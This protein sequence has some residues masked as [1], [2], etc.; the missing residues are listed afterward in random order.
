[1]EVFSKYGQLKLNNPDLSHQEIEQQIMSEYEQSKVNKDVLNVVKD[2]LIIC[3][4][5]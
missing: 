1:M 5:A 3:E 4:H 2:S